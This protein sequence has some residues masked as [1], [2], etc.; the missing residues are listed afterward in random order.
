M[1]AIPAGLGLCLALVAEGVVAEHVGRGYSSYRSAPE[2]FVFGG[3]GASEFEADSD[4]IRYSFGDGSLRDVEVDNQSTAGRIGF[5]IVLTEQ[6][7]F[8]LGYASLGTLSARG[9]SDGSQALNKGYAPGPVEID[10]DVDGAFIGVRLHSPISEPA[11]AFVRAGL[12]SWTMEGWV[13]DS[14]R[15]GSFSIEGSDPYLGVGFM[16]ALSPALAVS[17]SYDY[18][19]LEDDNRAFDSAADVLSLDMVLS[20]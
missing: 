8:E 6:V 10:G 9:Q 17:L 5:G 12:Y 11:A 18:Y 13:E 16:M 7:S 14:D 1:K 4:D 3:L 19:L 2:F 15:R 20:F